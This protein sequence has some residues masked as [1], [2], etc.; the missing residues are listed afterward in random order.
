MARCRDETPPPTPE[1]PFIVDPDRRDGIEDQIRAA[2][3]NFEG[4]E[5]LGAT[6]F[7]GCALEALLFWGL[8]H[9]GGGGARS[10][11][12][13][14]NEMHLPEMI[15]DAEASGIIGPETKQLAVLAKESRNLIHPGKVAR[16]G[17]ACSKATALTSLA[18]VFRV[19][20]DLGRFS[21]TK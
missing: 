21:S 16:S 10:S 7:G 3:A 4:H 12:R 1:L 19:I 8:E 5:W 6:I 15:D 14:T 20:E 17:V 9:L 11:K 2:W 18:A 13:Q